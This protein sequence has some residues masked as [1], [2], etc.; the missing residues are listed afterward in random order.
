MFS[1][2]IVHIKEQEWI[3]D[4]NLWNITLSAR[5]QAPVPVGFNIFDIKN[6]NIT[7]PKEFKMME[8]KDE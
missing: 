5:L 8:R 2:K 4:E 6:K 3:N 7:T 1:G